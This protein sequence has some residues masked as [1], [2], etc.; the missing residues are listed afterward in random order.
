MRNLWC[1]VVG[2]GVCWML[3]TGANAQTYQWKV[4]STVSDVYVRS[5]PGGF[6][7]TGEAESFCVDVVSQQSF[8]KWRLCE[9]TRFFAR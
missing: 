2:F 6:M 1:S 5:N 8:G 7:I 4:K 9:R 3:A